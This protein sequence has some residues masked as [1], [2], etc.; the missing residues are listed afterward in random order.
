M[1]SSNHKFIFLLAFIILFALF[2]G[3]SLLTSNFDWTWSR[4]LICLVT[5]SGATLAWSL[6]KNAP[7]AQSFRDV[8]FGIPNWRVMGIA[9]VI[10][11][12]MLAFF[13]IYSSLASVDLPL[14]SNWPWVLIGIITGVGIAEET[15]FRGY[16]FGF[17]REKRRFLKAATLS[18]TLFGTMHLLLLL[19]LPLP[20]AI[21]A[22]V[23]ATLAAYPTAYLFETGNRTIW[24]SAILHT[25]ALATN[26]F[27]IPAEL[28]VSLSLLWIGIV[29]IG[30]ILVFVIGGHFREQSSFHLNRKKLA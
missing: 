29:V 14:K 21:A 27:Q 10:S 5:V 12:L 9:V 7:L 11:A 3:L 24:P 4:I 19:W 15:L 28:A 18:M 30:L 2:Y 6:M 20:I 13:P 16:V 17:L 25:T 8:G 1:K 23:L 22:I 26:L